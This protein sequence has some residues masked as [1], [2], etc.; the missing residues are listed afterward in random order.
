[1][2]IQLHISADAAS[3][4]KILE[5][6]KNDEMSVNAALFNGELKV[7]ELTPIVEETASPQPSG[8]S[9]MPEEQS[10]PVITHI[11]TTDHVKFTDSYTR[12]E[13]RKMIC[14]QCKEEF[15][16]VSRHVKYCS[17]KCKNASKYDAKKKTKPDTG[18]KCMHCGNP[19]KGKHG[20][21]ANFCTL[22]CRQAHLI[23]FTIPEP[24]EFSI[25]EQK[26]I[27]TVKAHDE[28]LKE[29]LE[30]IKKT[31][32]PPQQRPNIKRSLIS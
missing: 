14:W 18:R 13:K 3:I 8:Q 2:D 12:G 4:M 30:K 32:P 21:N 23:A 28:Q 24:R 6:I 17:K 22:K 10:F 31:C 7:R 19:T 25:P 1:M 26:E 27:G 11:T 9:S 20:W 5:W 29:K 16:T 15:L